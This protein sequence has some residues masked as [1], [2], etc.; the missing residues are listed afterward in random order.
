MKVGTYS[1]INEYM[2]IYDNPRS[3]SFIDLSLTFVQGHSDSALSNFFFSRKHK[4][5]WRQI[6]YVASMGCWDENL[7]KCSCHMTKIASGPIYCKNSQKSLS[8]EQRDRWP[9]IWYTV[10]GT[11]VLPNLSKWWHWID[12]DH[13]LAWSNVFPN[14]SAWVKAYTAYRHVFPSLF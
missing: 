5:V 6:S 11:R 14:A 8:L 9:W 10:F 2:V 7:F 1:Q 3:R 12:H 4:T 13:F